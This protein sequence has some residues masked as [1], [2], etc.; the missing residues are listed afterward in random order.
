MEPLKKCSHCD[1]EGVVFTHLDPYRCGSCGGTRINLELLT[2]EE[3]EIKIKEAEEDKN[4]I[5][6]IYFEAEREQ[7]R[8]TQA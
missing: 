6:L 3:L 7:R 8:K 2:S 1:G 5:H 4:H